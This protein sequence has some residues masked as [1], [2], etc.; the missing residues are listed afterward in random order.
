MLSPAY[1]ELSAFS[2]N[3]VCEFSSLSKNLIDFISTLLSEVFPLLTNTSFMLLIFPV[4]LCSAL[5]I[6][7]L[8]VVKSE[9]DEIS[10]YDI[11]LFS[12]QSP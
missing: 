7:I 1:R 9:L 6:G 10:E 5:S 12:D 8:N 4:K 3:T 11:T 2:S